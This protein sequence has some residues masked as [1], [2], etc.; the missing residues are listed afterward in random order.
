MS[1]QSLSAPTSSLSLLLVQTQAAR[2][3]A[4][5]LDQLTGAHLYL[6]QVTS[7]MQLGML[8]VKQFSGSLVNEDLK[9]GWIKNFCMYYRIIWHQLIGE[10]AVKDFS[11]TDFSGNPQLTMQFVTICN[12]DE[13]F[14]LIVVVEHHSNVAT[15]QEILIRLVTAE[16]VYTPYMSY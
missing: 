7:F 2:W 16:I 12:R 5:T 10:I 4:A 6:S 11:L 8:W 13:C 3:K 14:H 15:R 1:T 9:F